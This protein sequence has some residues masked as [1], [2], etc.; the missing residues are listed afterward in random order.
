MDTTT[1][2]ELISGAFILLSTLIP[3]ISGIIIINKLYKSKVDKQLYE[4]AMIDILLFRKMISIYSEKYKEIE[5][6][7]KS[8]I[9]FVRSEA[10][11][12]IGESISDDFQPKK[13]K[14]YFNNET[15][16][17]KL[18]DAVEKAFPI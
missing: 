18:V 3:S 14:R 9:N 2:N 8:D 5:P 11:N 6:D 13:I 1:L 16:K 15:K 4:T 12:L 10:E 17:K 7:R